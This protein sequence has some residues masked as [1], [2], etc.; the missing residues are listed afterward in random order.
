MRFFASLRMTAHYA[1]YYSDVKLVRMSSRAHYEQQ[2]NSDG[3]WK[4][5]SAGGGSGL[6]PERGLDSL[7]EALE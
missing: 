1:T 2:I 5:A 7:V 4:A 3:K 6:L